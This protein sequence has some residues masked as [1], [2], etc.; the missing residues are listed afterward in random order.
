MTLVST[1]EEL[2]ALF[3]G[4]AFMKA[5]AAV[6]GK[7]ELSNEDLILALDEA[8]G[9]IQFRGKAVKGVKKQFSTA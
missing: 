1:A 4:T 2:P 5:G 8:V 6:K 9:G 3:Y 7:E